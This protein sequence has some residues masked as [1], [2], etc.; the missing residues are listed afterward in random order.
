MKLKIFAFTGGFLLLTVSIIRG[1]SP[2]KV[3]QLLN[4]GIRFY[5]NAD[6]SAWSK[7][8]FATQFWIRHTALNDGT[9][10]QSGEP[11]NSETDFALRRTRFSMYNNFDDRIV[12]YTQ[13]GFNN[14][15]ANSSKP[16]LYFHDI[17]AMFRVS[18]KVCYIGFGLN[19][20][21]GISRLSNTSFQKTLTADN[22]GFNYPAVNHS[23]LE[24]RQ[25]GLFVK[26]TAG[27]VSYRAVVSKPFIYD[28]RPDDPEPHKGYEF[29]SSDLEYKG[30]AAFHFLDKEYFHTS[31]L[32][33]TYLGKKRLLNLGAG[34][35]IY[36]NSI[37]EFNEE[38]MKQLKNRILLGTDCFFEMPLEKG[39]VISVYSVFY[40]FHFG[41]NYLRRSGTMN[42]WSGG[43][44]PQGAGNNEY[45]IGTGSIWYTSCGYLFPGHFLNAPGQFQLFYALSEKNFEALPV[46]LWGHD[47]G[48]NYYITGQKLKLSLQYSLRPELN[49]QAD[50]VKRH[51]GTMIFQIQLV[52]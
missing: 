24:S 23:D 10:A 9:V 13:F 15:S 52:I 28:G 42:I 47:L 45:K 49:E 21:N 41:K 27:P 37:A 7:I 48:M 36:P 35:D 30:Y 29:P 51:P 25:L 46:T 20:W 18:P 38:G 12:L 11:L 33:M 34:F 16:Q 44:G 31:Y 3:D 26:G 32:D 22:P 39:Q 19:G 40:D 6:S 5:L 17:W 43:T 14:L 2:V 1:A 8:S 4:N 50:Q